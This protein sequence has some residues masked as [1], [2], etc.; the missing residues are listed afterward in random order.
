M[1]PPL[2]VSFFTVQTMHKAINE[3]T[4]PVTPQRYE[5]AGV[6]FIDTA[7]AKDTLDKM[8]EWQARKDD[9]F[10]VSYPK[11][12]WYEKTFSYF[13]CDTNTCYFYS[14]VKSHISH[15]MRKI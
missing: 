2:Y 1:Y 3:I 10:V 12:G 14:V 7:M 15:K 5:Y 4:D 8:P 13:Q 9:V 11:A 6:C